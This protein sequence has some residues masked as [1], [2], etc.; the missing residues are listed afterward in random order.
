MRRAGDIVLELLRERFGEQVMETGRS[1]AGLFSSWSKIVTEVWARLEKR[2]AFASE[3][4]PDEPPAAAVHSRVKEIEH[5]VLFV[6]ADHP[7][8]IQILQTRQA[9]LLSAVQRKFPE[10]DIR[11]I[12]FRLCR[13][14]F[15]KR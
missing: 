6:E 15:S 5:G 2:K 4:E 10:L 12:A 9:E 11:T 8:W 13:E 1:T 7:G 14:P 3:T